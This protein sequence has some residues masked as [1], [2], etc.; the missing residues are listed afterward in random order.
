[1]HKYSRLAS[2][3]QSRHNFLRNNGAFANASDDH[4]AFRI[5]NGLHHFGKWFVDERRQWL[6]AVQL[7][8]YS[9]YGMIFDDI[10]VR[11]GQDG[12]G[13]AK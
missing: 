1:M 6:Q 7:A 3:V 4:T 5:E 13:C 9:L 8:F 11:W 12:N 2:R 10:R